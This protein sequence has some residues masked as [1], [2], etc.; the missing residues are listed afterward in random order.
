MVVSNTYSVMNLSE[1][2]ARLESVV[3]PTVWLCYPLIP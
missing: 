3:Y 2:N 1:F